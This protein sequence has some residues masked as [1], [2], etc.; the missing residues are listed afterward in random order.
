VPIKVV[1]ERLGHE[2]ISTTL[3]TYAHVMEG[4]QTKA[5]SEME[6]LLN[7][8]GIAKPAIVPQ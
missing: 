5:A 1:S 6:K 4:D 2:N 8:L 7:P 3:T